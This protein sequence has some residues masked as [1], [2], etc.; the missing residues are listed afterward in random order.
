VTVMVTEV[1]VDIK[2]GDD[3]DCVNLKSKGTL[4]VAFLTD[5][6]FDAATIDPATISFPGREFSGFVHMQGR[7]G[8]RPQAAL[9]DV[10]G[11]GDA[12]L[13]VH[14]ETAALPLDG[15]ETTCTLGALTWDG[16]LVRGSDHIRIVGR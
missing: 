16:Y 6:D 14:L 15:S 2:P 5:G 4:P 9:E 13:V 7:N 8:Q 11:D 12:D 10:D 1:S 3:A